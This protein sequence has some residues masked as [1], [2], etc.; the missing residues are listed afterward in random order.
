[1][2]A[3]S[4]NQLTKIYRNG[5]KA[6]DRLS[7]TVQPGEIFTL[8][9]PN[10]AGKSTLI[11]TLTT[12]LAP[13]SGSVQI[14][15]KDLTREPDFVRQQIACVAQRTSIDNHLS[16]LE[17]LIFQSRLYK[18]DK[19]TAARRI[20]AL[21]EAF[22]LSDY[23]QNR[24]VTYSGGIKRR[25]DI[26]MSM[27]SAPRLL[28]LDEPSVAL[29]VESRKAVWEIIQTIRST[30]GT[31]VLMTTHYLEEAEALSDTLC[32]L[33]EGHELV[34]DSPAN[35]RQVLQRNLIQIRLAD[36]AA[37]QALKHLLTAQ[38]FVLSLQHVENS[39]T[40]AVQDKTYGL[41][42][43]QQLVSQHNLPYQT[44]GI[45]EPSLEDVFLS[46]TRAGKEE[47]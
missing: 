35:L 39:L 26:A 12:Y 17:N 46:L 27:V 30:Y 44:L 21:I 25:L 28:F 20:S 43:V 11:Q 9:G 8:L 18:L 40:L 34:Q 14:F 5:T 4:V 41:L 32:I 3:V 33:K 19:T 7:L 16:L 22:G 2:Q 1:L 6:L 15:G 31:T 29:D 23:T 38:D 45:I 10:G 24:V 36:P 47:A 13:T 42:A 37:A